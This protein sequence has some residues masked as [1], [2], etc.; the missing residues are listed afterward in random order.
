MCSFA[1]PPRVCLQTLERK[2]CQDFN[3]LD[4]HPYVCKSE[5][6]ERGCSWGRE[7]QYLHDDDISKNND[8]ETE[9][10]IGNGEFG[11]DILDK[12]GA[13]VDGENGG[14][15]GFK[16]DDYVE[17]KINHEKLEDVISG[18]TFSNDHLDR[19]LE[20]LEKNNQNTSD[21]EEIDTL[22]KVKNVK[23]TKPREKASRT[24]SGGR[25]KKG[26]SKL[27]N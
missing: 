14:D 2:H 26:G 18:G 21:H 7:C 25:G 6:T 17:D 22:S 3:C 27:G 12:T 24:R 8:E 11:F 15:E 9:L 5:K 10:E 23:K 20:A 13:N 19:I 16:K 1:H 4:R